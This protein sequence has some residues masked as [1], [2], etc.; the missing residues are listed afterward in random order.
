MS[1]KF[2]E[3]IVNNYEKLYKTKECYDMKIYAGENQ[4]KKEFHVILNITYSPKVLEII[5]RYNKY[6]KVFFTVL[7]KD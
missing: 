1:V 6:N 2:Y 3:E 5:L 7:F 4:N